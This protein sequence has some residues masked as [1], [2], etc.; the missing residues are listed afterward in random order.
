MRNFAIGVFVDDSGSTD[1]VN[2]YWTRVA[3]IVRMHEKEADVAVFYWNSLCKASEM[4]EVL[5][6]ATGGMRGSGGTSINS[7]WNRMVEDS[8]CF[9]RLVLVTD[10]QVD[11]SSVQQVT[12]AHHGG[13]SPTPTLF[14]VAL[15]P[16]WWLLLSRKCP[17][18]S[19]M[20]KGPWLQPPASHA[21]S[22]V[23]GFALSA[24]GRTSLPP[25]RS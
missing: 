6:N 3:E 14:H 16:Q 23:A 17:S 15:T 25:S 2:S 22:S 5:A 18:L 12:A 9:D 11:H 8:L 1:R 19:M 13:Q 20:S 21:V 4:K 7:V 24:Q 10:G